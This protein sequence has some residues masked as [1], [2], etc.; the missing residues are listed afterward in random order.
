MI[1]AKCRRSPMRKSLETV[2]TESERFQNV[3]K[4][5]FL[6]IALDRA[7]WNLAFVVGRID[8]VYYQ[9]NVS[10]ARSDYDCGRL[11]WLDLSCG[12]HK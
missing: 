12:Q 5:D 7:G 1:L 4:D 9:E 6:C 3:M 11:N 8:T 2:T 10:T